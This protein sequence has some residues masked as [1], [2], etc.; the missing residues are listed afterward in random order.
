MDYSSLFLAI[1]LVAITGG[2]CYLKGFSNGWKVYLK[3]EE[4]IISATIDSLIDD[5]F[6]KTSVNDDGNVILLKHYEEADNATKEKDE[7][8]LS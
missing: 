1:T 5:G 3:S 2:M 6:I 7:G 8:I 4:L